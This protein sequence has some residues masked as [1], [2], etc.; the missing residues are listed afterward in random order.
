MQGK[1]TLGAMPLPASLPA[2]PLFSI[3]QSATSTAAATGTTLVSNTGAPALTALQPS[4]KPPAEGA[5]IL[6][7]TLPPIAAKVA[8]KIKSWQYMAMKELL[9]ENMA[10]HSQLKDLPLQVPVA[11]RPHLLRGIDSP[12]TWVFCFL[13]YIA[14]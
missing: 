7:S 8:Q 10:L 14:V 2:L 3:G 6:S 1:A 13:A 11:S 9:S 4:L 5:V 12:L